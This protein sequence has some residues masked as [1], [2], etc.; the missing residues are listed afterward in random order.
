[1]KTPHK[2][3]L[4]WTVFGV[5]AVLV[6]A[7]LGFLAFDAA[8]LGSA[9]PGIEARLGRPQRLKK[10]YAV[11]VTVVNHGDATAEGVAIEVTLQRRG[12]AT[13]SGEFEVAFLPRQSKREGWV[14]FDADPQAGRLEA[15]VKGFEAP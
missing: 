8:T 1:M 11:P 2:N 5:G 10:G 13:Q 3:W 9:P 4:E 15:R 7:T 6:V 12:R 14:V